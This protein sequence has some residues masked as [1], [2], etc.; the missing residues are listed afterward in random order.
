M[1]FGHAAIGLAIARAYERGTPVQNNLTR[2]ALFASGALLPDVDFLLFPDG[3]VSMFAHRGV[4]HSLFAA[5]LVGVVAFAIGH[6]QGVPSPPRLL[7]F[8]AAVVGSHPIA[9][10]ATTRGRGVALLW[11]FTSTR[12]QV[13]GLVRAAPFPPELWMAD[14]WTDGVWEIAFSIPLVA[15]ALLPRRPPTS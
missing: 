5:L 10:L 15:Y 4:T 6:Q 3:G 11:P 2:A 9:D 12:F 7:L 14:F 13:I 1:T 8:V